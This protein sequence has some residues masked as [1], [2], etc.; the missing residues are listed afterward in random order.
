MCSLSLLLLLLT[1][2]PWAEAGQDANRDGKFPGDFRE[3]CWGNFYREMS[4]RNGWIPVQDY[5]SLHV[6]VMICATMVNT[7]TDTEKTD[8]QTD[9]L[10]TSYT[11][12][13]SANS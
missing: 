11:I 8:Q 10:L 3:K 6:A 13:S 9:K 1:S 7:Q 4:G 2:S 12:I 5:K